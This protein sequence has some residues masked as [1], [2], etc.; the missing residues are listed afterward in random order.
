[1]DLR[2]SARWLK[3]VA[4]GR[5]P[6]WTIGLI[7]GALAAMVFTPPQIDAS[8]SLLYY[9]LLWT[10]RGGLVFA[11]LGLILDVVAL[12]RRPRYSSERVG[13]D[14]GI[15]HVRTREARGPGIGS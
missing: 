13:D 2:H 10:I 7:L 15:D 1:M 12:C 3:I 9:K 6:R 14:R 4:F 8:H 11:A 5:M